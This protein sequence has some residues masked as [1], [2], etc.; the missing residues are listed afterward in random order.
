[1]PPL[2]ARFLR[3]CIIVS[4][5]EDGYWSRFGPKTKRPFMYPYFLTLDDTVL[6]LKYVFCICT[7]RDMWPLNK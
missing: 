5:D 3:P 2:P 6:V 7:Q 4:A 1:M